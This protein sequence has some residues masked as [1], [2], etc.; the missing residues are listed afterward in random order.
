MASFEVVTIC[1]CEVITYCNN[2]AARV[3]KRKLIIN[4]A[5]GRLTPRTAAQAQNALLNRKL[6]RQNWLVTFPRPPARPPGT[7]E[8]SSFPRN[9]RSE[10]IERAKRARPQAIT[11]CTNTSTTEINN[12]ICKDTEITCANAK[13]AELVACACVDA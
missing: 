12:C 6:V 8:A 1:S 11:K 9:E 10:F 4:D 7:S 13:C 5:L 3:R 2:L